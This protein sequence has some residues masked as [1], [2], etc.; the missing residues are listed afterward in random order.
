MLHL[1]VDSGLV[2]RLVGEA[3][4]LSCRAALSLAMWERHTRERMSGLQAL[5]ERCVQ[6]GV[7]RGVDAYLVAEV[8]AVSLRRI[9]EPGFLVRSGLSYRDAVRELYGLLLHGLKSGD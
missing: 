7:F 2:R 8:M 6:A 4:S 3:F 1:Q 9:C 5:I